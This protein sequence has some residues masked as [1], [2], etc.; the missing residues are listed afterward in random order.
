M[1]V[2]HGLVDR[3]FE[4][5]GIPVAD[6]TE[7]TGTYSK[8]GYHIVPSEVRLH[9]LYLVLFKSVSTFSREGLDTR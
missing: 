4:I 2:I 6:F 7:A 9:L 1:Q 3:I 8:K 5:A